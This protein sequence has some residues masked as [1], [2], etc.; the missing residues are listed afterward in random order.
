MDDP[1]AWE[2]REASKPYAKEVLDSLSG[3]DS[4]A[5]WRLRLELKD[6]WP[7]TAI[8]SIGAAAQSERDW[9]FRWDMLR[10]YP[11]NHLLAKHL[12]KAHRK[13]LVRRAKEAARKESGAV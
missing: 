1:R 3:L 9:T 8:S 2:I 4:G 12:V 5:A 6:K 13:S 11:G 10:E 7:N